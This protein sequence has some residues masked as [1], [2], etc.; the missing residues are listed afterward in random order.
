MDSPQYFFNNFILR[1]FSFRAELNK[2]PLAID[3]PIWIGL[4]YFFCLTFVQTGDHVSFLDVKKKK[5]KQIVV[6]ITK[7]CFNWSYLILSMM[8][9]YHTEDRSNPL[10]CK[11]VI[12]N[13]NC[14]EVD[15]NKNRC[16][17]SSD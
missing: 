8:T 7:T 9:T 12:V 13:K 16:I 14:I 6:F 3:H 1:I 4:G 11:C 10:G 5:N 17:F 15:L 2:A